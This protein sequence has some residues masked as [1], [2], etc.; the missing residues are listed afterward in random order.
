[1]PFIYFGENSEVVEIKN[2]KIT[3]AGKGLFAK[4]KIK[5]GDFICWYF[6][7]LIEKD[8]VLNE[9]YDSDYLLSNPH[10]ELII[11]AADPSSCYGRYINDSLG[12]KKNNAEFIFYDNTFSAGVIATKNIKKGEEIYLSYGMEFWKEERR[13]NALSKRNREYIDNRDSGIEL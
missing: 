10:N 3:D 2:S 1:M 5:K 6:G 11:D 8:F 7:V 12:L 9:Y 4:K 13:Y